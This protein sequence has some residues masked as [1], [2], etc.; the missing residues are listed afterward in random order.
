M[1]LFGK[2]INVKIDDRSMKIASAVV[3]AIIAI[4]IAVL[5]IFPRVTELMDKISEV[6][7]AKK[8]WIAKDEEAKKKKKPAGKEEPPPEENNN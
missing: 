2:E 5:L 4:T 7:K 3:V 8:E 6:E 1:V